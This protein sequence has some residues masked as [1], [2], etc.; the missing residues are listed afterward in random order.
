MQERA[1]RDMRPDKL[2]RADSHGGFNKRRPILILV[3]TRDWT[4][5]VDGSLDLQA[6]SL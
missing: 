4:I 5:L 6:G 2:V 3:R 1:L